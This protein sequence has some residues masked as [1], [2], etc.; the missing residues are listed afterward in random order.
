MLRYALW[1]TRPDVW[2]ADFPPQPKE[3]GDPHG[4]KAQ[5][6]KVLQDDQEDSSSV[7]LFRGREEKEEAQ[8]EGALREH[9]A[10]HRALA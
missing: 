2:G 9:G 7:G 1:H 3:I 6:E 4:K 8:K 10:P 5:K